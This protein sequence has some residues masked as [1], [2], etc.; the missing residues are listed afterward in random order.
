MPE[1]GSKSAEVE[2]AVAVV[3]DSATALPAEIALHHGLVITPMEITIGE[4]TF[5]DGPS[6]SIANFYDMMRESKHVPTTNAPTPA[7]WLASIKKASLR[8]KSVLCITLASRVSSA[9]SSATLAAELAL[10]EFPDT[11]VQVMDSRAAA[12]SQALIAIEAAR[13]ARQGGNMSAVQTAVSMVANRVRLVAFIDTLEYIWRSGRVRKIAFLASSLFNIKPVVEMTSNQINVVSRPR[14]RKRAKQR[15]LSEMDRDIR[16]NKAHIAIMHADATDE[17]HE[18][19]ET[20][21]N[22]FDCDELLL[23][24]FHPFMGAHTGPGLL[25]TAYWT[26]SPKNINQ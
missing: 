13:V 6:G 12:G 8:A 15:L 10:D 26:E 18:L 3:T 25:A 14:S 21:K 23:T 7:Q 1:F 22:R 11:K 24:P 17:A 2:Q 4:Q 20:V 9:H 16:G 5:L 19:L